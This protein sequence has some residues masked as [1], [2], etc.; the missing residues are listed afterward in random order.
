V[1]YNPNGQD[2]QVGV[3]S[4]GKE[5]GNPDYSG[6]YAKVSYA[7]DWIE[8][9]ISKW[10]CTLPGGRRRRLTKKWSLPASPKPN[11]A[12]KKNKKT[13]KPVEKP[14]GSPSLSPSS[15]S[16]GTCPTP[17]EGQEWVLRDID[18]N[19]P[20]GFLL[21]NDKLKEA[22]ALYKA[23][24]TAS[25]LKYGQVPFWYVKDVTDFGM[26][27]MENESFNADVSG[28]DT[29]S[30]TNMGLMFQG[31][32]TF[33]QP[34]GKWNTAKVTAMNAMFEEA[35]DFNQDISMWNVDKVEASAGIFHISTNFNQ[36]MCPWVNSQPFMKDKDLNMIKLSG[37][38]NKDEISVASFCHD[39]TPCTVDSDCPVRPCETGTCGSADICHYTLDRKNRLK[40]ELAPGSFPEDAG[41]ELTQD[42]KTVMFAN[43]P[44]GTNVYY[45]NVDVCAGVHQMCLTDTNMSGSHKLDV[46]Y[47]FNEKS[48]DNTNFPL[49]TVKNES[50]EKCVTFT[51]TA[52]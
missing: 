19:D 27:F 22:V 52:M 50:T 12:K 51:V 48:V 21:D 5:C 1:K 16:P 2:T 4:F 38:D 14:T 9:W 30:V 20:C 23:D 18:D 46:T 10:D 39:C 25:L 34:I 35:E 28:W 6:V 41:Y 24:P 15:L 32:K 13:K 44:S 37:C 43:E 33:N 11:V 45:W 26:L 8:E 17:P 40:I 3:V 42:G 7:K 49:T 31:A 47:F 29:S 36:D